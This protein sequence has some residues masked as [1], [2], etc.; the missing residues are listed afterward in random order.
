[1]FD[2]EKVYESR[3]AALAAVAAHV[4]VEL[5]IAPDV[6]LLRKHQDWVTEQAALPE[7]KR[8]WDQGVWVEAGVDVRFVSLAMAPCGTTCCIAGRQGLMDGLAID[9]LGAVC[10]MQG[11]QIMYMYAAASEW[12]P[13]PLAV[14]DWA[15]A[16]MGLDQTQSAYLFDGINGESDIKQAITKIVGE[17]L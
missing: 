14:A 4:G 7:G 12:Q 2:T 6:P 8:E 3:D 10:D 17:E 11:N 13:V 16:R 5:P 15:A 9:D 1:M